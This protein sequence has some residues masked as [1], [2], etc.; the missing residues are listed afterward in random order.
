MSDYTQPQFGLTDPNPW[1]VLY[2]PR[3]AIAPAKQPVKRSKGV[4]TIHGLSKKADANIQ[5][6]KAGTFNV[7]IANQASSDRTNSIARKL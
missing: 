5:A 6:M 4:L 3:A 7:Q 2:R 1:A